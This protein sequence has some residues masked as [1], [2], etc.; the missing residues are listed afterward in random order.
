M[1]HDDEPLPEHTP[2][3]G[4]DKLTVEAVGLVTEALEAT[5]RARGHLY[6]FHQLTG[7]ADFKLGDAVDMLRE[8]GHTE[9]ADE[10]EREMVGRNVGPGRWTFQ[11]V[12]EYDDLYWSPFREM[13]RS[14]R[15]RLVE[16]RR[17]LHEANLKEERRTHGHPNH[18]AHP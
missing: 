18:T 4:V 12:E 17:H 13:E 14:V 3:E 16:G 5:E 9:I 8:A 1:R 7:S 11:I 15:D 10:I 6:S 2:P